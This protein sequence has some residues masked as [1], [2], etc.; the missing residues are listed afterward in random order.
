MGGAAF[1]NIIYCHE[2]AKIGIIGAEGTYSYAFSNIANMINIRFIKV[3][4]DIV[5]KDK[6]G[7]NIMYTLDKNKC[8]RFI[9]FIEGEF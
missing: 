9:R 5:I 3:E 1:T 6:H 2:K 7:C 4:G 8:L